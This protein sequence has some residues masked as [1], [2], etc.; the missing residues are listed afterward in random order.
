MYVRGFRRARRASCVCFGRGPSNHQGRWGEGGDP[1]VKSKGGGYS[2]WGFV[3]G[4]LG[5]PAKK[6]RRWPAGNGSCMCGIRRARTASC[7]CFGL[8]PPNHQ[9]RWGEGGDP[10][11]V[12][13]ARPPPHPGLVTANHTFPTSNVTGHVSA[14][15]NS[16]DPGFL[17]HPQ[18]PLRNTKYIR[19]LAKQISIELSQQS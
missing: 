6:T 5:L 19:C 13:T 9:G 7:V 10:V 15:Q 18:H 17:A 14:V 4:F 12:P 3:H 11:V 16:Q 2:L 8:G 1:G